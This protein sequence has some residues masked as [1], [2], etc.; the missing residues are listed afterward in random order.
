MNVG[1]YVLRAFW[2]VK[3]LEL[4]KNLLK[5]MNEEA[6]TNT[7]CEKE[8]GDDSDGCSSSE[9][10]AAPP[11]SNNKMMQAIQNQD[12][13]ISPDP[14]KKRG[15]LQ[16]DKLKESAQVLTDMPPNSSRKKLR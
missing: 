8:S 15:E 1:K 14:R 4:N 7:K 5:Q 13:D 10:D 12:E 6:I 3:K 11:T 9:E 2:E 16:E